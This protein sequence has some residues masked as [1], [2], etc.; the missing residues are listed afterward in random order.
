MMAWHHPQSAFVLLGN[1]RH[2]VHRVRSEVPSNGAP[3]E[4]SRRQPVRDRDQILR[5]ERLRR[6]AAGK[7]HQSQLRLLLPA[8]FQLGGPSKQHDG[9]KS[10]RTAAADTVTA[11]R[12]HSN[13]M[14]CY[15]L[16]ATF[17]TS[18]LSKANIN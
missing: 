13:K 2:D 18:M 7:L 8:V 1:R 4:I 16:E 17:E 9:G 14:S 3:A 15:C 12:S 11:E 10:V 6:R 5:H